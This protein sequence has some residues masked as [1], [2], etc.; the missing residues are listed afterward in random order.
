MHEVQN[1]VIDTSTHVLLFEEGNT[2]AGSSCQIM[3]EEIQ[4]SYSWL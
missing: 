3:V 2:W 4:R 1:K